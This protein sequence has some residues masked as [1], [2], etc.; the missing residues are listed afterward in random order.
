MALIE[1]TD[2]TVTVTERQIHGRKKTNRGTISF[3]S[4]I[5]GQP[6]GGIP[7]PALS[8]FGMIRQLDTLVIGAEEGDGAELYIYN[9]T[10]NK[11]MPVDESATATS[12]SNSGPLAA[13]GGPSGNSDA[14]E[15]LANPLRVTL[16][17]TAVG[18]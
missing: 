16:P 11:L 7:L 6:P 8:A 10:S 4:P 13:T 12:G 18:W 9:S 3:G 2:V 17:Y 1:H 15:V 5:L 14:F